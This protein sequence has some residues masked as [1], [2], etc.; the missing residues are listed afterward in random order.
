MIFVDKF[1]LQFVDPCF[2]S[3]P[4]PTKAPL[5]GMKKFRVLGL[6]D[7]KKEEQEIE[8]CLVHAMNLPWTFPQVT[9]GGNMSYC[10]SF[11]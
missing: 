8:G 3:A 6:S 7:E 11:Q 1:T 5:A 10:F 4:C 9:A 2:P